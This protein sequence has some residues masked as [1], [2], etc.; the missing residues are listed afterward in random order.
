MSGEEEL[1]DDGD[2]AAVEAGM[3]GA[4]GGVSGDAMLP[5]AG[6][7]A[8]L[9][10]GRKK[11]GIDDRSRTDEAFEEELDDLLEEEDGDEDEEADDD[12]DVAAGS[13]RAD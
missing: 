7:S 5:H 12:D 9:P 3:S 6:S 10:C 8:P 4:S 2:D 1:D 13:C 11:R